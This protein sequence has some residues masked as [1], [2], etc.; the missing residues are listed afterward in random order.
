MYCCREDASAE[1]DGGKR[2]CVERV[3][4]TACEWKSIVKGGSGMTFYSPANVPAIKVAPISKAASSGPFIKFRTDQCPEA[5]PISLY[6]T[7]R[8]SKA[9][10]ACTVSALYRLESAMQVGTSTQ[11]SRRAELRDVR[12]E[13]I[14]RSRLFMA[15]SRGSQVRLARSACKSAARSR[16]RPAEGETPHSRGLRPLRRNSGTPYQ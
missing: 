12:P 13:G 16:K 1:R 3:H 8:T 10:L 9:R 6:S 14:G 4:I 5:A 7:V 11:R 2:S 15:S